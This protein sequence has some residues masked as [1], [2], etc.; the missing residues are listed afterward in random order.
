M[1]S[2]RM[3]ISRLNAAEEI[4]SKFEYRSVEITQQRH[5]AQKERVNRK[6][7]PRAE[8]QYQRGYHPCH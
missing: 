4:K 8:G 6:E 2:Q 1:L 3:L 5:K 7:Y